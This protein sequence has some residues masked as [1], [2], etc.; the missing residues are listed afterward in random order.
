LNRGPL[1]RL[2]IP[3]IFAFFSIVSDAKEVDKKQEITWFEVDF[4]PAYIVKGEDSGNGFAQV[5]MDMLIN[6]MPEY[7]H[8]KVGVNINR[9]LS[10]MDD[11]DMV[12]C[13]PQLAVGI[14][15]FPNKAYSKVALVV[16]PAGIVIRKRDIDKYRV[17]ENI[18]FKKIIE[19]NSL[20]LGTISNGQFGVAIDPLLKK[21]KDEKH[22]F[23]REDSTNQLGN[24]EM[25]VLN[26]LDYVV[27]YPFSF[28]EAMSNFDV[29]EQ[30]KL[31]FLPVMEENKPKTLRSI[32]GNNK[33]SQRFVKKINSV[34]QKKSYQ[35]AVI[36]SLLQFI[37][38]GLHQAYTEVNQNLIGK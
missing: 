32:C 2:I 25:L 14:N 34:L 31:L 23:F 11:V 19:T 38:K 5:G 24:Y 27:D 4:P 3:P 15:Q 8:Y 18:S 33:A 10:A 16:P 30:E 17:N 9:L 29:K 28:R 37:P 7:S 35:D 12:Q 1:R 21:H 26:R 36:K 6:E 13:A 22:L 20:K